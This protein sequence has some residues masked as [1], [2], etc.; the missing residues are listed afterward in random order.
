MKRRKELIVVTISICVLWASVG[1]A[2]RAEQGAK[3]VAKASEAM[4][5]SSHPRVTR[6]ILDVLQQGGNAIDAM[7]TAIPLQHVVEPQMSTLAGGMGGLIYWADTGELIYL[8]AELDH[9]LGARAAA[10]MARPEDIEITSGQRIGVPGTVPGLAAAAK[11]YGTRS[12]KDYFGPAIQAASDGFTMYSF[13]YGEMYDAFERL[14]A[15]PASREKW[16]PGGFLLPVGDT[17]RQPKLAQTLKELAN[18]GPEYFTKGAWAQRFVDEVNRTGGQI[19]LE[20]LSRYEARWVEPMK[21]SYK[22][23]QLVGAPPASSAGIL[24]GMIFN[25]LEQMDLVALGH[26]TESAESFYLIRKAYEQAELFTTSFIS[27]PNTSEIPAETLLSK[28]F[29]QHLATLIENSQPIADLRDPDLTAGAPSIRNSGDDAVYKPHMYT[30]TNHLVIVDNDGNWV[31]M[32][33]TVYG[34]TFGTGLSVDGVG[35]NSGNNFPGVGVG[36][37]RRVITPFPALMAVDEDGEPWLAL[38]S[39]GLSSRAVALTLINLIGY[40]MQPYDAVDAPRFQGYGRY[41][42]LHVESRISQEVLDELEAMGVQID[43]SAP[44]NWHMGSIQLITRDAQSGELTGVADPRRAGH[45]EG[46]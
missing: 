18:E 44:Y 24:N 11:R 9:T 42:K 26:Y 43:I 35:V 22:G 41:E 20:E 12:W 45:A 27:D 46:Y 6:A 17:V 15:H 34:D 13:L 2:Q 19:T 40:G 28:E 30:D 32:T 16:M 36:D 37:G 23:Q 7:L 39:P 31:S 10:S 21:F 25:I 8:D 33:H 4:A 5:S 14:G 38:G 1:Y 29:G 3:P